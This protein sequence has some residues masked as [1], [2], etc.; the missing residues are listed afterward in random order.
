MTEEQKQDK[1]LWFNSM[2]KYWRKTIAPEWENLFKEDMKFEDFAT[3]AK[4][5]YRLMNWKK[6]GE[7]N[8]LFDSKEIYTYK[9]EVEKGKFTTNSICSNYDE[10]LM[11]VANEKLWSHWF[12]R[13]AILP[14]ELI[15]EVASGETH[16]KDGVIYQFDPAYLTIY[17]KYFPNR[18]FAVS[19]DDMKKLMADVY[20]EAY[21]EEVI[22]GKQGIFKWL[23]EKLNKDDI[24]I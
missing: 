5:V 20:N 11:E 22:E 15:M 2:I 24:F 14:L 1:K 10:T 16:E 23:E 19:V 4:N 7:E 13:R 3:K 18:T 9:T 12:Y 17:P 6:V 21:S 8:H